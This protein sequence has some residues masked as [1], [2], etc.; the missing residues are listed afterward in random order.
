MIGLNSIINRLPNCLGTLFHVIPCHMQLTFLLPIQGPQVSQPGRV[1]TWDTCAWKITAAYL[2]WGLPLKQRNP[3]NREQ[4]R[5]ASMFPPVASMLTSGC[6]SPQCI[7]RPQNKHEEWLCV[8]ALRFLLNKTW[9]KA[10]VWSEN[11]DKAIVVAIALEEWPLG[12]RGN[13]GEMGQ[14]QQC[15]LSMCILPWF[16]VMCCSCGRPQL[17]FQICDG[18]PVVIVMTA[19]LLLCFLHTIMLCPKG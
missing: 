3:R 5:S 4:I 10:R 8:W 9:Y 19:L 18:D 6:F 12:A 2:L 7:L 16:K 13:L 11:Q 1:Q 17:L 14:C 15:C